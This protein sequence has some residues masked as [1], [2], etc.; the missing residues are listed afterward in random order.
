MIPAEREIAFARRESELASAAGQAD[1]V[2]LAP[3]GTAGYAIFSQPIHAVQAARQL[4][5]ERTRVA[6][7]FGDLEMREDEP[8]GPPLARA[9]RLVAVAHPGQVLLSSDRPRGAHGRGGIRLGGGVARAATTSSDSTRD[10]TSTNSWGAGSASDFPELLDRPAA[11]CGPE[12]GGA[13]GPR[14]RAAL[15]HRHR[16]AR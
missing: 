8:V 14:L 15:G 7:D 1:G 16:P 10:C 11:A 3:R 5:N 12:R 6:I 13:L 9:A 4:V 2:K